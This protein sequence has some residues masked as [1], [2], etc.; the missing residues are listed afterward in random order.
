MECNLFMYP[1]EMPQILDTQLDDNYLNQGP[2]SRGGG[3]C[4]RNI[5]TEL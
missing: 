5:F 3:K 1:V 2:R 4:P